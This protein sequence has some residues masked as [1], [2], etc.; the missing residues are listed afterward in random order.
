MSAQRGMVLLLA[1]VLSLLLGLFSISA[2]RDTLQQ[3]A[4]AGSALAAARAFEE[5]EASLLAGALQLALAPPSPC[6]VCV[7]PPAPHDLIDG[8]PPW[9]ASEHGF[10]LVQQLGVSTRAAHM[11][12]G[13]RVVLF[14]ITAVS[15]QARARQ[16]LE[17]IYA[18]EPGQAQAPRRIAWRQRFR[19]S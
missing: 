15:R 2:L 11:P 9:Q 19:E 5:A 18:V 1:L 16:V 17:A 3:M 14:R 8:Q 6:Q 12:E 7:P 13:A 4:L 10:F